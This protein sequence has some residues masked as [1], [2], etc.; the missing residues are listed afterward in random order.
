MQLAGTVSLWNFC[1]WPRKVWRDAGNDNELSCLSTEFPVP[2]HPEL[3][4]PFSSLTA[5]A[6][7][8]RVFSRRWNA[9]CVFDDV[10]E[11]CGEGA[12]KYLSACFLAFMDGMTEVILESQHTGH[13]FATFA[14][15]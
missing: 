8:L 7:A 9:V 11:H 12:H 2:L 15:Q 3:G 10:V 13:T 1:Y 14:T 4:S 6:H 5:V